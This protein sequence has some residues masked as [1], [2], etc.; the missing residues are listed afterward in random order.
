M[1]KIRVKSKNPI[2]YIFSN[3][4]GSETGLPRISRSGHET[5]LS[6]S[7]LVAYTCKVNVTVDETSLTR[8]YG[9]IGYVF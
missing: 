9:V 8:F 2:R 4:D 7:N 6:F 3:S 1:V 5:T